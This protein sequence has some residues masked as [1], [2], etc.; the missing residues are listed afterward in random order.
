MYNLPSDLAILRT[1]PLKG[2][3]LS[4]RVE[5]VRWEAKPAPPRAV[6]SKCPR[7]VAVEGEEDEIMRCDVEEPPRTVSSEAVQSVGS[8]GL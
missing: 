1:R 5:E 2:R 3:R 8:Q 4:E 6:V 7:N